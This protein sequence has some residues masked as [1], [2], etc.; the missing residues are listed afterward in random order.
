[1]SI[2][3]SILCPSPRHV[4]PKIISVTAIPR[5]PAIDAPN[6][7]LISLFNALSF[8][9]KLLMK[10]QKEIPENETDIHAA[11]NSI[12]NGNLYKI[13]KNA[14][15][16]LDMLTEK[17][18][19]S[20]N[21]ENQNVISE[22]L[23]IIIYLTRLHSHLALAL[24]NQTDVFKSRSSSNLAGSGNLPNLYVGASP[25]ADGLMT[26]Y[27]EN[28]GDTLIC[29]I[30]DKVV[31]VDLIDSHTSLCI[32]AHQIKY[33]F[34]SSS[35]K[36]K[37]LNNKLS[38]SELMVKFP[39]TL[40][41]A[42]KYIYQLLYLYLTNERAIIV[43]TTDPDGVAQLESIIAAFDSF[44]LPSSMAKYQ[45]Y[46]SKSRELV[47]QKYESLLDITKAS[48][49][50]AATTVDHS[51]GDNHT[52]ISA[53]S[54]LKRL[55]SGAFARVYL[56]KKQSTGDLFAIKVIKKSHI[57]L[58][59]QVRKVSMERDIMMK[60]HSPYMVN[61]YYSFIKKNNIYLVMEYIPGGDIFSLLQNIGSLDE[62]NAKNYVAQVVKALEFLRDNSIIHRDLK[63]DNILID[64]DGMLRLT[65]FGLSFFGINGRQQKAR[66]GTPDYMAPEII[67]SHP[68]SYSCDYWSL[69]IMAYEFLTGVPPFHGLSEDETFKRV[70]TNFYDPSLL[71]E[72]SPE[73]RDF[74]KRLLVIN[75]DERLGSKDFNEILNHPWFKDIDWEHL[76]E[77]EPV[78]VPDQTN[79][80]SYFVSRYEFP[81]DAEIDIREDLANE[82]G[83][84]EDYA[85]APCDSSRDYNK[86]GNFDQKFPKVSLQHLKRSTE[87]KAHNIR[88]KA[89]RS[90]KRFLGLS[91]VPGS[92]FNLLN[93]GQNNHIEISTYPFLNQSTPTLLKANP[94]LKM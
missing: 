2:Q 49:A 55:S 32:Q 3:P 18:K 79:D 10:Y 7:Q 29:R 88:S 77:M 46:F 25:L 59:N 45:Q 81:D 51:V 68:H 57:N 27:L 63:P 42:T 8:R 52:Q 22:V 66:V 69:G 89:L 41:N 94:L 17:S 53:F 72:F 39:G 11:I 48:E 93:K 23:S 5:V 30:C 73:C 14:Q 47:V 65:D 86:H 61:F 80:S 13:Q 38:K 6:P 19:E 50:I 21:S 1:M 90:H 74:I 78:F 76:R 67:I 62:P 4:S 58:K 54:F 24:L 83:S 37:S 92:S 34:L 33:Q 60:L 64:A 85:T 56:A 26:N 44:T 43:K 82:D 87:E 28:E 31:P 91:N 20:Q 40:P 12:I 84:Y 16:Y 71:D 75:P 9:C 15:N 70:L 36:L 35:E